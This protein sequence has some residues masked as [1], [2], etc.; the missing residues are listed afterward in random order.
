MK[1]IEKKNIIGF[2]DMISTQLPVVKG[3]TGIEGG[4]IGV[5]PDHDIVE[6]LL[7]EDHFRPMI[8]QLLAMD[9][10]RIEQ[11]VPKN[12]PD[13]E[14]PLRCP[15]GHYHLSIHTFFLTP[16]DSLLN[17]EHIAVYEPLDK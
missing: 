9:L 11:A 2:C 13:P 12:P 3:T 8:R 5:Q 7:V 4:S 14:D 16:E 15:C 1:L 17:D 6:E 10:I